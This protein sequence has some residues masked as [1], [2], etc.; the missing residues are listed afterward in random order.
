MRGAVAVALPLLLLASTVAVAGT[1]PVSWCTSTLGGPVCVQRSQYVPSPTAVAWTYLV[2]LPHYLPDCAEPHV[3]DAND[4]S[5]PTA[6]RGAASEAA[7]ACSG[8]ELP[9]L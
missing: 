9:P 8:E 2:K 7:E 3:H 6:A 1:V 5:Q 4:G